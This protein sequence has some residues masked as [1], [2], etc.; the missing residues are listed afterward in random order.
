[1]ALSHK[2]FTTTNFL[3]ISGNEVLFTQKKIVNQSIIDL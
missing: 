3:N 1:M 2:N